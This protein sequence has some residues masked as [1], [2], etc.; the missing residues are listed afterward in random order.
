MVD[1]PTRNPKF[2]NMG[3]FENTY[4]ISIYKLVLLFSS[5]HG[6]NT[7]IPLG[8][9]NFFSPWRGSTKILSTPRGRH[10]K[11]GWE[12]LV[13]ST[14]CSVKS[15]QSYLKIYFLICFFAG[16]LEITKERKSF[17]RK[18]YSIEKSHFILFHTLSK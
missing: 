17:F 3:P 8:V 12:P 10:G 4:F 7:T 9:C 11:K 18:L 6:K 1:K 15:T 14:H 5:K 13:Y 2:P 16:M